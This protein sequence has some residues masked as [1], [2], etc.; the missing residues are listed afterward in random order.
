MTKPPQHLLQHSTLCSRRCKYMK[1]IIPSINAF[2]KVTTQKTL[3][4]PAQMQFTTALSHDIP[5]TTGLITAC[6][7]SKRYAKPR[8]VECSLIQCFDHSHATRSL[9]I[10]YALCSRIRNRSDVANAESSSVKRPFGKVHGRCA[11]RA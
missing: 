6:P 2:C 10:Q 3:D 11:S 7:N 4:A 8:H 1:G 9:Q 5:Y